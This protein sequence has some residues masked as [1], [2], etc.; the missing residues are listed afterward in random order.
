MRQSELFTK[1]QKKDPRDE[2]SLNA[3]LLER[4]GFV[5]KNSAGIYSFLPLGWRV[6][7]KLTQIIREEMNAIGGQ[8]LFMPALVEK[9]YLD[10]SGRWDVE[11]SF[12]VKG[13]KDRQPGFT[14]GWTHEEVLTEIVSKYVSSYE[15]LPFAAYQFQTKFRNEARSK[16]GLLR[17][18]EFIMKD[19]YSFHVSEGD[20]RRYYEKVAGAYHKIF[21]RCGV[22]A[23]Y[24]EAAGGSFTISNTHEFQVLSPVGEDTIFVC[25]DCGYAVNQDISGSLKIKKGAVCAKCKKGKFREEKAIEVGNI[26]PLGTKYSKAFNLQ[27]VNKDGKKEPV[28]MGSYGIGLGRLMG[29]IVEVYHDEKGIVWPEAAAPFKIHLLVLGEATPQLKKAGETVY[30]GLTAAGLEVLYDD[31]ERVSPGQKLFDADLIGL[32][33]RLVV[34]EKTLAADKIELKRRAEKE[35]RL[36]KLEEFIKTIK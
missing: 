2:T 25:D 31:R 23:V 4:G 7:Q 35:S 14:L 33:L 16:S 15:D 1:T 26:F 34:S 28:V 19:L 5:Y 29:T 3:K 32:P 30:N 10:A 8:E 22:E 17:G 6:I 21:Q 11:I 20:L 9:R 36:L 24:T 18:R 13:K 12:E 27:F